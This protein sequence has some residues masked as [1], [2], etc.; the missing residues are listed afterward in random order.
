MIL[1]IF[2]IKLAFNQQTEKKFIKNQT[3]FLMWYI[4]V[5]AHSVLHRISIDHT[6]SCKLMEWQNLGITTLKH[7]A[8]APNSGKSNNY[9]FF[10]PDFLKF[11]GNISH[12]LLRPKFWNG[13]LCRNKSGPFPLFN[14]AV[15]CELDLLYLHG[16]FYCIFALKIVGWKLKGIA[17]VPKLQSE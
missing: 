11:C 8:C 15:L 6:H 4:L 16:Q 10:L 12:K 3:W 13:S 14:V 9:Q 5:F 17:M 1:T 2:Q 7:A